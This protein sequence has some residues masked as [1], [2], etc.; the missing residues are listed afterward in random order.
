MFDSVNQSGIRWFPCT[1]LLLMSE[2][3]VTSHLTFHLHQ[4]HLEHSNCDEGSTEPAHKL[5]LS[6][7]VISS[8]CCRLKTKKCH[9]RKR[10]PLCPFACD[11][12]KWA[13]TGRSAP[14]RWRTSVA[15]AAE[16]TLTAAP[17]RGPSPARQRNP[18]RGL[19]V[20]RRHR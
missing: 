2:M 8:N 17:S 10:F 1:V 13:A 14:T 16:T 15:S 19:A 7:T 9:K 20:A 3:L 6:T 12:R 18:V 4:A 5:L 11:T